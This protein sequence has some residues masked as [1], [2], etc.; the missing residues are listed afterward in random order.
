MSGKYFTAVGIGKAK[1]SGSIQMM[2]RL[3]KAI[4]GGINL[5]KRTPDRVFTRSGALLWKSIRTVT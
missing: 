3:S 5:K 4:G 1:T 2:R